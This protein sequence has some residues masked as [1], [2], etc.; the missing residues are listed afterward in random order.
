MLTG[1]TQSSRKTLCTS[2]TLCI[3][4]STWTGVRSNPGFRDETQASE[5]HKAQAQG[6]KKLPK[7][8][9]KLVKGKGKRKMQAR[10]SHE[11]PEG[12]QRYKSILSLSSTL[13]GSR[14]SKP[15]PDSFTLRKETRYPSCVGGWVGLRAGLDGCGK[16]RTHRNEISWP[17]SLWPVLMAGPVRTAVP[18]LID[19]RS[20]FQNQFLWRSPLGLPYVLQVNGVQEQCYGGGEEGIDS[21][22]I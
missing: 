5:P 3:V 6:M 17:I 4:H 13:N 9:D 18:K 21:K 8:L 16:S 15:R 2:G 20:S 12:E 11:I 14:F 10:T 19:S 1:E 7:L 22:G